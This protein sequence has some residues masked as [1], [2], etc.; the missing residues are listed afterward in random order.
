MGWPQTVHDVSM[1][2]LAVARTQLV[3]LYMKGAFLFVCQKKFV[4]NHFL[5][6]EEAA[7][8]Q[9][10]CPIILYSPTTTTTMILQSK[11]I[12]YYIIL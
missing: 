7:T 9:P 10:N 3:L 12:Y 2:W 11:Y 1:E 8:Q 5:R 4:C 6:L